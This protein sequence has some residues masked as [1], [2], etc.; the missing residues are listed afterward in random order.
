MAKWKEFESLIAALQKQTAGDATVLHNQRVKGRSGRMRQI[1]IMISQKVGLYPVIIV[2]ECKR[3]RRPVGIDKVEA[4]VTKLRDV[5]A[6]QGV[7]IS[8]TGFDAGARA[9]AIDNLVTLL[10]YRETESVDWHSVVGDEAWLSLVVTQA[11]NVAISFLDG[12]QNVISRIS[13]DNNLY[14]DRGRVVLDVA[15]LYGTLEEA[16]GISSEI[17]P[18]DCTVT[19]DQTL[20]VMT[21]QGLVRAYLIAMKGEVK[22]RQYMVNLKLASG[23]VLEN[24]GSSEAVFKQ[25]KSGSIDKDALLKTPGR[26]I[27]KDEYELLKAKS[28]LPPVKVQ[29]NKVKRYLRIEATKTA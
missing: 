2:I 12:D 29:L 25:V 3:H 11:E 6:S 27:S 23:H 21:N 1:D 15:A 20:S 28:P 26:E 5:S 4:F 24:A 18:F 17:G 22:G 14:D 10:S 16:F 7:M 8:N 19:P 13:S 9:I